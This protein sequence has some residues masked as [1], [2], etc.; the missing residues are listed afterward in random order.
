MRLLPARLR[1]FKEQE[2]ERDSAGDGIQRDQCD[3]TDPVLFKLHRT[4]FQTHASYSGRVA[5]LVAV[6]TAEVMML[7]TDRITLR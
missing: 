1:Q 2:S 6:L 7:H 5:K 3:P 4:G